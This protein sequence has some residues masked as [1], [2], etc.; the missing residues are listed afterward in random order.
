MRPRAAILPRRPRRSTGPTALAKP[1]A[2]GNGYNGRN[3]ATTERRSA[4]GLRARRAIASGCRPKCTPRLTAENWC[5]VLT[6]GR[7]A[8]G[9]RSAARGGRPGAAPRVEGGRDG[10]HAAA[11]AADGRRTRV[12]RSWIS[13]AAAVAGGRRTRASRSSEDDTVA[14]NEHP[15]RALLWVDA[16]GGFL[17]CL[18]D[19]VVLGQPS[20]GD[21]I[22]VP[23]L[24]DL[25][26]RHAV[27]RRD[28][29][30]YVLEPLQRTRVDGREITGAVRARRQPIDSTW[31]QCA[32][33][34]HQ[35]AC[36]ERHGPADARKPSQD[37]AVGRRGAA[38][39]RQLRAGPEPALPRALPRLAA[40]CGRVPTRRPS[41]LPRRRAAH[42]S[43]AWQPT[44]RAKFNRACE[45]KEKSFRSLGK[46]WCRS[47]CRA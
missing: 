35:A 9:D 47:G 2:A 34:L 43:T 5:A 17:V 32:A 24:A 36:T 8:A 7:R 28:A 44:A 29:G 13:A 40:R 42:R 14:G 10:R 1:Q 41:V 45:W 12:A 6:R 11:R 15:Q 33:A 4:S 39:G 27:I 26:R 30:A 3:C 18:D 19:C 25:S 21:S 20:P 38:D 22:A 23:I 31:R 46:R 37:A 16:V